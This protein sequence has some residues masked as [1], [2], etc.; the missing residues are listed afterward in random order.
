MGWKELGEKINQKLEE[1]KSSIDEISYILDIDPNKLRRMIQGDFSVDDE[2]HIK[3]Y[4]KKISN[5]FE[6]DS[7]ELI[8]EY[9]DEL[10][11]K[12]RD[13]LPEKS[14]DVSIYLVMIIVLSFV[15]VVLAFLISR[16]M[17]SPVAILRNT[18]ES[19]VEVSGV[20]LKP[21]EEF[22]IYDSVDVL[23]NRGEITVRTYSGKIYKVRIKNFEVM[24]N[25]RD[26]GTGS[27]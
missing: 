18:S 4:L 24:V 16:V 7:D 12:E 5:E 20:I 10:E 27:R 25:G 6:M 3:E 14:R 13:I 2:F 22:L 11:K 9:L 26:K 17:V 15:A 23:N 8:R 1:K 19:D 21:G